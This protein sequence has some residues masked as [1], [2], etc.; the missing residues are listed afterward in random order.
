MQDL[1]LQ[2][3]GRE[4]VYKGVLNK[5]D[6]EVQ[7]YLFDHA[8]LFAKSVKTKSHEQYRVYRRVRPFVFCFFLC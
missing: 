1:R 5:R 6:G 8:L 7:V 2:E 4:M 3:D